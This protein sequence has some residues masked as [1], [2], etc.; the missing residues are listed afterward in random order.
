MEKEEGK[1]VCS[2]HGICAVLT[3]AF[4]IRF[5]GKLVELFEWE[6]LSYFDPR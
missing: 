5:H 2:S 3:R 6:Y 4:L 1:M